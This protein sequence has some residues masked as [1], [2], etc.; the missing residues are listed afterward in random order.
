MLGTSIEAPSMQDELKSGVVICHLIN[1]IVPNTVSSMRLCLTGIF[2]E[3]YMTLL[4]FGYF[5]RHK[6]GNICSF[7]ALVSSARYLVRC[8]KPLIPGMMSLLEVTTFMSLSKVKFLVYRSSFMPV[9]RMSEFKFLFPSD[10]CLCLQI[11]RISTSEAP[12]PQRENIQS[13]LESLK[14]FG[15]CLR[16]STCARMSHTCH[17]HVTHIDQ[18]AH[19]YQWRELSR[20]HAALCSHRQEFL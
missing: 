2:L 5:V 16:A 18:H 4:Y 15:T 17:T 11:K 14:T 20:L 1:R 19:I 9:L 6:T 10:Y 3:V 13:F 8:F 12:F 7:S